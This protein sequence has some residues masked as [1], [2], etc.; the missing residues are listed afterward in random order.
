MPTLSASQIAGYA[1]NAGVSGQN[2]SIATAIA[3]AESGGVTD[4]Q[5]KPNTNGTVDLGL[6]QINS[7]HQDLL[8]NADWRDP[9]QNAKMMFSISSGGTNWKPWSTFTSGAYLAHLSAANSAVPD[10]S[11]NA[12]D[13]ASSSNPL[14]AIQQFAQLISDPHTWVR[15]GLVIGGSIALL[16]AI[17]KSFDTH[18]PAVA[19]IA[20]V[21]AI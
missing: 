20:A 9:A 7:V 16:V 2:V 18:I 11:V 4:V 1:Q 13:T 17:H 19:K 3:L 14:S 21:A 10:T 12:V 6:W 15:L 5:S 8:N